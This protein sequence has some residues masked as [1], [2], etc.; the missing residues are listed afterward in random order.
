L[1]DQQI[2][3]TQINEH[4]LFAYTSK[5][6]SS[7]YQYPLKYL[8]DARKKPAE[9]LLEEAQTAEGVVRYLVNKEKNNAPSANYGFLADFEWKKIKETWSGQDLTNIQ[10]VTVS[11][12]ASAIPTTCLVFSLHNFPRIDSIGEL[13]PGSSTPPGSDDWV[14]ASVKAGLVNNDKIDNGLINKDKIDNADFGGYKP[15]T[16]EDPDPGKLK[17]FYNEYGNNPLRSGLLML[18]T[19]VVLLGAGIGFSFKRRGQA[20]QTELSIQSLLDVLKGVSPE[21]RN[22][23]KAV[24]LAVNQLSMF[25]GA[26]DPSTET[27]RRD[28]GSSLLDLLTLHKPKR[29]TVDD[30]R[31]FAALSNLQTATARAKARSQNPN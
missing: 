2:D 15:V 14:V 6:S 29:G 22:A 3:A 4:L 20:A 16:K 18:I 19:L 10:P 31:Y 30:G 5:D 21:D 26:T 17:D 7:G 13:Q 12:N 27:L 25:C 23:Q 11:A 9:R 28:L 8:R 1:N 24:T